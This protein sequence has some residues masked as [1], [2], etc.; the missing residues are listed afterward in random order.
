MESITFEGPNVT[1]Y[2]PT[3][4]AELLDLKE[5]FPDAKL[6]NGNTEIGNCALFLSTMITLFFNC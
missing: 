3:S 2:R 5:R 1:W 4:L 6:V